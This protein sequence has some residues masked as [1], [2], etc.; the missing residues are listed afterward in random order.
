MHFPQTANLDLLT[1]ADGKD[2]PHDGDLMEFL[3]L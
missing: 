2:F 3:D 1:F